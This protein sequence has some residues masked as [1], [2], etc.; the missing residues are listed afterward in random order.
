MKTA[1]NPRS[2]ASL[3]LAF[4]GVAHAQLP[5][6]AE[7]NAAEVNE[8]VVTAQKREENIQDVP[9][10]I[11]A[12]SDATLERSGVSDFQDYATRIPNLAF[13]YTSSVGPL[14][15]SIA[16]R[17]IFGD[18]TTGM[19]LDETPLPASLDP[20]VL[21][22]QRIEALRGPQGTL[23]GAR[24]MGGT[25]RLITKQPDPDATEFSLHGTLSS[26]KAGGANGT[27]DG[28]LNLP[29]VANQVAVRAFG[30]YD[31]QSGF[32]DRVSSAGAAAAFRN[33]DV[34][35]AQRKGGQIA[36]VMRL[37]G[38][39]LTITPRILAE[40]TTLDGRTLVDNDPDN[41]IMLRPFDIEEPGRDAWEL[42]T[43][44][45][46]YDAAVGTFTS[47]TSWFDRSFR[48][49]EDFSEVSSLFFGTPLVP[50]PIRAHG[51]SDA[52]SQEM[53]FTSGL[54]GP[55]R[56]TLGAFYQKSSV[57]VIFPPTP[58]GS[59]IDNVYSQDNVSDITEWAGFGEARLA[60]TD[61]LA[62]IAGVRYF[63]NQVKF[64]SVQEGIAVIPGTYGG[65]QK[66]NGFNPKFGLQFMLN[67]D[68]NLFATA[69]KGFR[70]GGVNA[71]PDAVCAP[72]YAALGL[73]PDQ[74]RS[75]DSDSLW[76][77]EAGAKSS[78]LERRL[79]VNATAFHIDWKD[80]QQR[81]GLSSCGSSIGINAGKAESEGFELELQGR[82]TDALSLTVA[83]GYT[84]AKIV[85]GGALSAIAAGTRVQQ[86]PKWTLSTAVDYDFALASMPVFFHADYAFVDESTSALNTPT[87][88]RRRPAYSLVNTRVGV[89][90]GSVEAAVFLD[91]AFDE[92]INYADV[93]ALGVELPGRPRI[94]TNRS[95]TLGIEL[96]ARF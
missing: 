55:L 67:D 5:A 86:V 17:G 79:S 57:T 82:P 33:K 7:P 2:Y 96:R 24:S 13:A 73:D 50:V 58:I 25:V 35:S 66:E 69:A 70:V 29:I 46:Q 90:L 95:R 34:N 72:D 16:M 1:F 44:T 32:I 10:S 59:F 20:R 65:R 77:Y 87:N 42:Y 94:S 48:D 68:I 84:D 54:P 75:F 8:V 47:A 14:A 21:D 41:L 30:Y 91:N 45:A 23:Y 89:R 61:R 81:I 31:H 6:T 43:L 64:I 26:T 56:L 71:V 39:K 52:F 18:G 11:T 49:Q 40:R 12:L 83:G 15:Q 37:L 53:R 22:L 76:S 60:L 28:G 85:D 78:W 19:Y 63:D 51:D 9:I 4:S 62:L 80:V 27:L 88:P 36:M 74:V 38:D 3:I 92:R 93:P